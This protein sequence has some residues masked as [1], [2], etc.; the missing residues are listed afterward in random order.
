ME[1]ETIIVI[2][3]WISQALI[4]VVGVWGL[5]SDP[6]ETNARTGRRRLNRTGW[7]KVMLLAVGF[8]LFA[9]TDMHEQKKSLAARERQSQQLLMQEQTI[10]NQD[11]NLD[12]LRE[13]L[14]TQHQL[15]EVEIMLVFPEE[16]ILRFIRAI[17][18]F[19]KIRPNEANPDQTKLAYI[20]S[21]C[22]GSAVVRYGGRDS[23]QIEYSLNRPQGFIKGTVS[24]Q[25]PEW[26]AFA[27]AFS[28]LLGERFEIQSETGRVLIDLLSPER[29]MII[30]FQ[31][32][33]V[34]FN[35]KNAGIRLDEI[36]G[37]VTFVCGKDELLSVEPPLNDEE[38]PRRV[39]P[40]RFGPTTI[41]FRSRDPRV[42]WDQQITCNWRPVV[43]REV[44][45]LEMDITAEV[46]E[47]RSENHA[48]KAALSAL[49]PR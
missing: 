26:P 34:V 24:D 5:F 11:K 42:S 10:I 43:T 40:M 39:E 18:R 41:R 49:D 15:S 33:A 14:L 25:E 47:W 38:G 35:L 37:A 13:L 32:E 46:G 8:L 12:Y 45:E 16:T 6:Y 9:F 36:K 23:G 22:R 3:K 7:I 21:S 30:R 29:P 2:L 20:A 48:I 27:S 17:D 4:V 28:G 31:R 1:L 44:Y 19:K